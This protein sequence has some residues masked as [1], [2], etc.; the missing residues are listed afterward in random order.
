MWPESDGVPED[1]LKPGFARFYDIQGSYDVPMSQ[2]LLWKYKQDTDPMMRRMKQAVQTA[3]T[4]ELVGT[5]RTSW[6]AKRQIAQEDPYHF[7]TPI[8]S[9]ENDYHQL[10][11]IRLQVTGPSE[12]ISKPPSGPL[13][14]LT[15]MAM[16]LESPLTKILREPPPIPGQ[17]EPSK[18]HPFQNV[19]PPPQVAP[20]QTGL[21]VTERRI[22]RVL[23]QL[24]KM[25]GLPEQAE[26]ILE[27]EILNLESRDLLLASSS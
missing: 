3:L 21:S 26:A 6:N 27:A 19:P 4:S 12:P 1:E 16:P 8:E 5:F 7:L 22:M 24:I 18:F 23:N 17:P 14:D 10:E 15:K 13:F 9:Q 20:V 2:F 25:E 11:P